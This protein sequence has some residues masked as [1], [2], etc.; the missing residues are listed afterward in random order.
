MPAEQEIEGTDVAASMA[1]HRTHADMLHSK[2]VPRLVELAKA[3]HP[4]P[5]D[6]APWFDRAVATLQSERI[7]RWSRSSVLSRCFCVR[8]TSL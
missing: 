6:D 3:A 4:S 5:S 8:G 7:I 1:E 2:W